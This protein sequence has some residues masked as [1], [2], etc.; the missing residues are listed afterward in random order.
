MCSSTTAHDYC[1]AVDIPTALLL[2]LLPLLPSLSLLPLLPMLLPMLLPSNLD[3][4]AC[5]G[6]RTE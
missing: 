1:I 5:W 6:H 4:T 2:L 3:S